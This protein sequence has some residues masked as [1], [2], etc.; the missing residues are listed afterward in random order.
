ME[1]PL[2]HLRC[3]CGLNSENAL[4]F[5]PPDKRR[6]IFSRGVCLGYKSSSLRRAW[7][8]SANRQVTTWQQGNLHTFVT[9]RRQ[10][11][12]FFND[13]TTGKIESLTSLPVF[14]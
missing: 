2:Q 6:R 11:I 3:N 1:E 13:K 8:C 14:W 9:L 4:G 7:K 12:A 10:R 5:S